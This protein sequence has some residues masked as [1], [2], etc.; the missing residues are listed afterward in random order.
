MLTMKIRHLI[1]LVLVLVGCSNPTAQRLTSLTPEQARV[2]ARELA[3]KK[4]HA[5][6][7]SQPFS[8]GAS[9]RIIQGGWI[10]N[11]K[12]GCGL[13]DMEATVILTLDGSAQSVNV[14][15]LDSRGLY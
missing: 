10:W 3:N 2:I 7:G 12:K 9:A 15:L 14:M 4:A 6:Y 8:D 11:D 13:G 5:L 1:P